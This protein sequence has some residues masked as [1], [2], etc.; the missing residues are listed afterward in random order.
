[1]G[2]RNAHPG[3]CRRRMADGGCD[4]RIAGAGGNHRQRNSDSL[5]LHRDRLA[6]FDWQRCWPGDPDGECLES[7]DRRGDARD[8]WDRVA[9]EAA[10]RA[11]PG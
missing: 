1:M 9:A 10:G 11:P 7:I 5:P 4:I 8:A 6:V 3:T 2:D